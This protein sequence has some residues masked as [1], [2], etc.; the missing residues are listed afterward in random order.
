L[1]HTQEIAFDG[2]CCSNGGHGTRIGIHPLNQDA[3][4]MPI[5]IPENDPIYSEAGVRCMTFTRSASTNSDTR[6]SVNSEDRKNICNFLVRFY[7]LNLVFAD[8]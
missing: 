2:L 3:G 1:I 6:Q 4:C 5:Q 7:Y 8:K